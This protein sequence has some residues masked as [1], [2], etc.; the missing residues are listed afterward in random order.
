MLP[1][2]PK[3]F[4]GRDSE[5]EHILKNLT[6]ES[7]RISILG[8]GGMGKT[9]LA[10]AVLHDPKIATKYQSR[11]FVSCDSATR[12]TELA[13]LIGAHIGLKPRKDLKQ[14]VVQYFSQGP[15]TLLVLDNL[16]T[17]WEP[18]ESRGGVEELL[19]QLADVQHLALIITMRGA[20]RP[21]KVRWTR[22]FLLPLKPLQHDAARQTFYDI[23]EDFHNSKDVDE[24]L[25]VT[26]NMPLAVDLIAHLV[27][28]EGCQTILRRWEIEKT[29]LLSD[30][31]DKG[32]NLDASISISLSSPRITSLPGAKDLLALLSI[33]PDGISESDLLQSSLPIQDLLRCKAALL[34]T[35]LAY[36]DNQRLKSLVPIREYVQRFYPASRPLINALSTHFNS[37]LELYQRYNNAQLRGVV[38]AL[39]SNHGN[40]QQLLRLGLDKKNPDVA[41]TI[42]WTICL[43]SVSQMT[44]RGYLPL[45]D[46]VPSVFPDPTDHRLEAYYITEIFRARLQNPIADPDILVEKAK[47]HFH[48]FTDP[49]LE[50]KFYLAAGSYYFYNRNNLPACMEFLQKGLLLSKASGDINQHCVA[51]IDIMDIKWENGDYPAAQMH[52]RESQRLAKLSANLYAEAKALQTEAMCCRDLGDY[53]YSLPLLHRASKL[54]ELC[55]LSDSLLR[56]QILTSKAEIHRMKSEYAEAKTINAEMVRDITPEG[57]AYANAFGLLNIAEIDVVIG[58]DEKEILQN[59]EKAKSIFK[60]LEH[61]PGIIYC[62]MICADLQLNRSSSLAAL[63]KFREWLNSTWGKDAQT[64]TYCLERLSE[65]RF[66]DAVS[67]MWPVVYL[68]YAQKTRQRLALHN[69]LRC[70]GDV[71]FANGDHDTAR[72]LFIV[73]LEGF[74]VMDVHQ[75]KADCLLCLGRIAKQQGDLVKAAELWQ[76][77][78]PLF[79]RSLQANDVAIIDGELTAV[80]Q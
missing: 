31:Y 80:V 43:N 44:G 29:G 55:G 56:Y 14:A 11:F 39:R 20:E 62:D 13:S 23:A 18:R 19:S 58:V 72:S 12:D 32:A 51:L 6:E 21:A 57:N 40:L 15:A 3:I 38:D 52:A 76:E 77:A 65:S 70:L 53:A 48:T 22:P 71:F 36:Y 33:L 46:E 41:D 2:K 1:A 66:S 67:F 45:M 5:L 24:L 75:R 59:L 7:A 37:L 28:Y 9:S 60:A 25:N 49:S 78:R 35:S 10:K 16:D 63:E 47:S 4:H 26:D 79:E 42:K 73:A 50:S 69:A 17:S 74:T 27:D 68:G 54:L 8:A 64:V 34:A 30:G 61:L